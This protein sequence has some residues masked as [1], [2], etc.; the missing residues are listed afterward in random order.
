MKKLYI[1]PVSTVLTIAPSQILAGSL[2]VNETHETTEQYAK[3]TE[4][5]GIF[6]ETDGEEW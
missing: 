6:D 4:F 5:D 3:E 2:D 1:R